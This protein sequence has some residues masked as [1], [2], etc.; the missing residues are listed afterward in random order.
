[1]R[2]RKE[3]KAGW[4]EAMPSLYGVQMRYLHS[5]IDLG[6]AKVLACF[7]DYVPICIPRS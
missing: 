1:M 4:C 7:Y 3:G 2:G 6:W 5:F